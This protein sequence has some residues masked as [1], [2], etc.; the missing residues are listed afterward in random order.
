MYKMM[1]KE[2]CTAMLIH[3][4]D[5]SLVMV[6]AQQIE[7]QKLKERFRKAKRAKRGDNNFSHSRS[8]RH[9][10]SK[11]R[12][13]LSGQGKLDPKKM[14]VVKSF[15]RPLSPSDIKSFLGL[16][17]Y[18][19]R[20]VEGFSLIASPLTTLTH[21]KED[22]KAKQGLDLNLEELKEVVLKKSVEAFSQG[23]YGVLCYQGHFC[24]PN[25]DYLREHI[26]SEAHSSRYSIHL[27][28][29]KMYRGLREVYW[30]NGMKKDIVE[31]MA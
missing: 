24:V 17:G 9:G 20:F 4:M 6:H 23:V 21:P 28:A 15:P 8:E 5:I 11:F 29:S 16:D 26:L 13:R 18:Y 10:R 7:D 30:L 22:V 12:Q 3:D 14:V 25:V 19:R 31:F 2:Y 27:G 1:V